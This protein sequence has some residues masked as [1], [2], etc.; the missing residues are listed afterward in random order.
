MCNVARI[1]QHLFTF[2]LIGLLQP[3][4]AKTGD[5]F[6][7][8][9]SGTPA[10][11]RIELCLNG[12]G[13]LSC[14]LYTASHQT[15][16]IRT[17]VPDHVYSSV[18][19]KL[20]TPGYTLGSSCAPISNGYC[21]T[22]L[23]NTNPA[24]IN[25]IN[26]TQSV[27]GAPTAVTATAGNAAASV[28][29][30]AP[31]SDGGTPITNYT[32]TSSPGNQTCTA[33]APATTCTINGLT[34][35]TSYTFTA[36]ANNANG[37]GSASAPSSP[38]TPTNLPGAPTAAFG[39]A[40]NA[41]ATVSWVAPSSTG[42][43]AIVSYT[44][45]SSP[46]NQTCTVTAPRTTCTIRGLIN[47]ASYTFTVNARNINGAGPS[48]LPSNSVT[49]TNTLPGTPSAV[50]VSPGNTAVTVNWG[51]AIGTVTNYTATSTP[52]NQTCT[53]VPPTTTCLINNLTNGTS[54]TFT[55]TASNT[56]GAGSASL[57][58]QPVIPGDSVP[59]IPTAVT[60]SAGNAAASVSWTPPSSTG[61]S[62]IT[63]YRATAA[64]GG[65]GCTAT[66]PATTCTITNLTNG[67]PYTF[68]VTATNS[69]GT[70]VASAPSNVVTPIAAVPTVPTSI[71][72][73]AGN[74]T[75][76]LNW[77]A[78]VGATSY[79]ATSSPGSLTCTSATTTCNITGLNNGTTYTFTVIARNGG[80]NSP[81]S[82]PSAAIVP[83][84]VVPSLPTSVSASAGNAAAS[85]SWTLPSSTGASA[86]TSY[87]ATAAPG[88]LGCIATA[89]ATTCTITNL[90]NDTP[91]TF[92]V[93]ATNS[94]GTSVASAPS[95]AVTPTTAVP[96]VSAG[97]SATAGNASANLNWASVVGATS[98]IATSNPGNLTCTSTTTTCNITGLNNG[99]TY[100]FTVIARNGGGNSPPS[101]SSAAIVPIAVVPSPPTSVS[102]SA[103][104][105]AASVSWTPPSSTGASA[106]TSYIATAAP[107][108]LGC[109][110]T[111]PA[112][113]CTIT[114]L[115]ND[116]PY[117]F[118]VTATNSNGTS[119]ASAPSNAVTP[120]TAVPGVSAGIS[121][122]AGNASANLNWASVA[123]AASYIA[124]SN[125]GS[126]TCTS[127]TTTCN[128]TGLNN[129]T[130]Y[131][132]TVIARNGGGNSPPSS[133][134]AAIVPI[135]VVPS[136]PTAVSASAGNAAASVSW[137]PPSSTGASAITSYRATAAPGGASCTATAPAT[138]CT[139]T[140]LTNDTPYTFTVTATNSNGTS[141]A[142]APSNAVTPTTAVPG[143]SAGISATA[144]NA[145]AN[146]NWASVAGAAS[147]I[148]TSSPGNLTC[149][150]ATT[151][152]NITGLNNGT[153]YTF[154][155][156]ARN[157]GGNSPPSSPSAAVIPTTT[158]ASVPTAVSASAGNTLASISWT[159]STGVV[160]TYLATAS[161]GGASCTATAPATT[162]TITNLTN[163]TPYTFRVTATNS[164][165]TSVASA[166]SNTITP[167]TA[168]PGVPTSLSATA[169]NASANL[170]W[171]AVVGA[172]SYI[173]TSSPG[174]L[175][176]TSATTTCN[177]T[178]LNNGTT[179]TFTVIAR[180]GGRSSPASSPSAAI[181][182][183][184]VV[185]SLPTSVSA[186]GGN[187][188]ASVSWTPPSSTGAS[189]ITSYRATAAPGGLGCTATAPATTCTI[190][191]LTNGTPYT[192][193]VTATNSY[194]TS[195]ASA[196]SNAV[197]PTTAVPG[198]SAGISA[199]AGNASANLNWA[200]VAGA[201]SYI[202]TSNPGSLTCTSATTT[203]NITGLNNG[204]TY[205][206]T[207]IAR[208]GGGNSPPS[209]PS[210][211]IV[212][213]AVV[214]SPP[215]SVS[216]S[217]GNAAASVSWTPPSSTG[218]SAITSYI[219]TAAPG[220]LG[221]IATAP[222]TIC[223][224][225]NLT[226][227]TPYT[228]TVTATN[229]NGTSVA[230]APSNAVT[231]TTAVPGVSAGISATAGNAS[232][233]LN[234]ASVAGAASYIATS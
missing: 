69:N 203:C 1:F 150:S 23:S 196:L 162:C 25:V 131:T 205:T 192:F 91:Y 83:I 224:I 133:P 230:S 28:S 100:T 147:Y 198:V 167:T 122:T 163:D 97:I 24:T 217:A 45:T 6:S 108:G 187:A 228:F 211:A 101:S 35:G 221:C 143:V 27:P 208:N 220:G 92:T 4:I 75:A 112:T 65:L 80:G 105:A 66:A 229:S 140:N 61:A 123:G 81:P 181:V 159:A 186:S 10:S 98:Y 204:T 207:V 136:P 79:V 155:V 88:G 76:N 225:T 47:D 202:A 70:S 117:T 138:T 107:G 126:L 95:N 26:T 62:A 48:S 160:A 154:T 106:I 200:S 77:A 118:T 124:T 116:T 173:A 176:C 180:N 55:V 216:A 130:T 125:P 146:L 127:A 19:I 174:S 63:S 84:A 43:S 72:A 226:N 206:F 213:I 184:A 8:A 135:A 199:T 134:S 141:V 149:T 165:G 99:T 171:A 54:Y 197:T 114:N 36:T 218:A 157:G 60:G 177:I 16:S 145:S 44:A 231:P 234:W 115:T 96:G 41:A 78:V 113:I 5:L 137:T 148:A 121:A 103:G 223:T 40:G 50:T 56:N 68:T 119:V 20:L 214:P 120:T 39:S 219:A 227:D 67:T 164:Y 142:S 71:S 153:T 109:I 102:A 21:L 22:S 129:G 31:S 156:I 169:G 233:N 175:T 110:A 132:F 161:P 194:G 87:I 49:P 12:Q 37:T 38:V 52:G 89:P 104:N 151:T 29:W 144:G 189:A 18:G 166:P 74:G 30:T 53:S 9:E 13:R 15:L 73:T 2:F 193:R 152:C 172:T 195:V 158:L 212:P 57:P 222:A 34:N 179:Y 190:T 139:I 51:A 191:N 90:T 42:G 178:G 33:I 7:I 209:S 170:N 232:A 188:A 94:N 168:V 82:S 185:P 128:I 201:A 3:A 111:A 46:N 86:I 17:T 210:A 32:A 215:T 58:S 11:L 183:I 93:T 64:P 14:Q 59:D 85:V 182:P